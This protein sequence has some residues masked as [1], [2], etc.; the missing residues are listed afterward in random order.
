M[1]TLTT[2]KASNIRFTNF[3]AFL[4][5]IGKQIIPM[6]VCFIQHI[7]VN[8]LF[9]S[10]F[11]LK[12]ARSQS[13]IFCFRADIKILMQNRGFFSMASR[14]FFT[15]LSRKFSAIFTVIFGYHLVGS[16]KIDVLE[17]LGIKSFMKSRHSLYAL[18]VLSTN[19]SIPVLF[20]PDRTH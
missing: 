10:F 3:F 13:G 7:Y 11:T 9:L 18:S 19:G 20:V 16:I 8:F 5:W 12:N 17:L 2:S 6:F 4:C 1:K 14:D 15:G